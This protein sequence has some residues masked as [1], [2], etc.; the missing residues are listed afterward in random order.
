MADDILGKLGEAVVLLRADG[1]KLSEDMKKEKDKLEKQ[2]GEISSDLKTVGGGLTIGVTAP[3]VAMGTAAVAAGHK[4]DEAFDTIRVQ[5]GA[6]GDDLKSLEGSFKAVFANVP[7]DAKVVADTLS[8]V[9]TRTGQF[10]EDLENLTTQL[11]TMSRITETDVKANTEAATQAFN[12]WSIATEDQAGALDHVFKV[13]QQTG[14]SVTELMDIVTRNAGIFDSMN[15]SFEES[16]VLLGQFNKIGID[17][18][19]AVGALAKATATFAKENI[20]AREGLERTFKIIKDL[21]PSTEATNLAVEVFGVKAGPQLASAIAQGKLSV[22]E[23]MKSVKESPETIKSAAEATDGFAEGL[24]KLGNR[25]IIALEPLGTK[26]IEIGERAIPYLEKLANAAIKVGEFFGELPGPVQDTIIVMGALAAAA[27]PVIFAAGSII[28][29]YKSVIDTFTV[30]QRSTLNLAGTMP[31]LAGALGLAAKGASVVGVAFAG[32]Q[33]GRWIGETTGLTDAVERLAGKMM[34]LTDAEIEAGMAARKHSEAQ[35]AQT[36]TSRETDDATAALEREIAKFGDTSNNVA[37]TDLANLR[38]Q[39]GKTK[40]ETDELTKRVTALTNQFGRAAVDEGIAYAQTLRAI[41]GVQRLT[42]S[43]VEQFNKVLGEALTKL[44]L[45]GQSGTAEFRALRDAFVETSTAILNSKVMTGPLAM[46]SLGGNVISGAQF[47]K[48]T[49]L[50]MMQREFNSLIQRGG[51]LKLPGVMITKLDAPPSVL[52]Q[53]GKMIMGDLKS[54]FGAQ[55]GPT[56]MQALTGGGDIGKSVGG[57]LGQ[58][59]GQST[60][61]MFGGYLTKHLGQTLGGAIGSIIPGL[62]TIAGSFIGQGVSKLVSGIGSL[63]GG[64]EGKK[65]NDIRD[66]FLKAQGGADALHAKLEKIGRLDLW[67]PLMTGPGKIDAINLA[68][69]NVSGAFDDF[70]QKSLMGLQAEDDARAR[71]QSAIEK[72]GFTIEELGPKWAAQQLEARA[73]ELIEDFTILT[74]SGVSADTVIT[75][76]ADSIQSFVE[77]AKKTGGEVPEAMRPM[78]QRMVEM[79]LLVDE[80][81]KAY[82]TLEETGLT[83]TMSMS[84]GFKGVIDKLDELI[85]K[86]TGDLGTALE[87]IPSPTVTVGVQYET[88]G[89]APAPSHGNPQY[90]TDG[91]PQLSEG[92]YANWGT[93]TLAML[94]GNEAVMPIDDLKDMVERAAP[95]ITTDD[96]IDAMKSAGLDRPNVN[97]A[98]VLEG[99]LANEMQDFARRMWP[100]L[101]RVLQDDGTLN[102]SLSGT[103]GVGS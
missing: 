7:D 46:G 25:A 42:N 23:L 1:S 44:R 85:R 41:G 55:L 75:K 60:S 19:K 63:F 17:G 97:F 8:L 4:L 57:L 29:S 49:D 90:D 74:A 27:G 38:N 70:S 22:D 13:S 67:A 77:T 54:T 84:E 39:L 59:L 33:V 89:S 52:T 65:V 58:S 98:P 14:A 99:A 56:I 3:I 31:R 100:V 95:R 87:N 11:L 34:G 72:Y 26:L 103:L 50:A 91:L 6:T 2:L 45:L 15:M 24:R 40:D 35:K 71:L 86:I 28:G 37:N 83:F 43:E 96:I 47:K 53:F 30:V 79:G 36:Q 94:H 92:G 48:D 69:Q 68:I 12:A 78:L 18:S 5:T 64:G 32:W 82:E 102:S 80:N 76:M 81:D 9:Q 73:K 61:K 101:I 10:G 20:P 88:T 16:V 51:P 21:G 93:G 66:E 62:G